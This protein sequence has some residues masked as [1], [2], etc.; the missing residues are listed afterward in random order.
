MRSLRQVVDR[1]LPNKESAYDLC[2]FAIGYERRARHIAETFTPNPRLR[3]ACAFPD[4]K[5]LSYDENYRWFT[6]AGYKA[7]EISDKEFDSWWASALNSASSSS[8]ENKVTIGVDVS[9]F[10]RYK[11]AAIIDGIRKHSSP[12]ELVVDF[13]YSLAQY[14]PPSEEATINHHVGPVH[15]SFAGWFADA[16]LPIA[17]VVGLGYEQDKALGAVEHLQVDNVWAFLPQSPI[18]EYEQQVRTANATL[19]SSI[20]QIHCMNYALHFPIET[21]VSLKSLCVSL[22]QENNLVLL[23]FGPKLFTLECLLVATLLPE[24]SVWR[25]SAGANLTPSERLPSE[26]VF[27]FC[28]TWRQQP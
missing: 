12:K 28:T 22:S 11:L 8:N 10:N 19:L 6:N 17:A 24:L 20:S 2:L 1:S 18:H 9:C 25:V 4:G 21:L 7:S 26:H 5:S 23:P 14:S 3:L 27:S 13:W 16:E 15:N